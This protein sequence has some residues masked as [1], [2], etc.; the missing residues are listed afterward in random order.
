ML[1]QFGPCVRLLGGKQRCTGNAARSGG[2]IVGV[3]LGAVRVTQSSRVRETPIVGKRLCD[4]N[5]RIIRTYRYIIMIPAIMWCVFV[6][7]TDM[8]LQRV[9][10]VGVCE[11]NLTDGSFCGTYG[12]LRRQ[13]NPA[14]QA[15]TTVVRN[16]RLHTVCTHRASELE[17]SGGHTSPFF[18]LL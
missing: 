16:R 17:V 8:H 3:L 4:K 15:H 7:D 5:T 12:S 2:S 14:F 18:L 10:P 11:Y 9:L 6:L 13:P 1:S